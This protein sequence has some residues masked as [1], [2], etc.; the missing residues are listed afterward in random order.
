MS[1]IVLE[2]YP[3]DLL[4]VDIRGKATLTDTVRVTIENETNANDN[5]K[6]FSRFFDLA[7]NDFSSAEQINYH[8]SALRDE[9]ER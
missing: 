3:S 1:R 9:W 7:G 8:V 2:H 6:Q 4:P 5:R